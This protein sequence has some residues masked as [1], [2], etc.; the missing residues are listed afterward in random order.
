M[1]SSWWTSSWIST[2]NVSFSLILQD[3]AGCS[4]G[5]TAV[6]AGSSLRNYGAS[7]MRLHCP[8]CGDILTSST[9]GSLECARGQMGLAPELERRLRE[10]YVTEIRQPKDVTFTYNDRPHPIG[11]T[12]FCPGCGVQAQE[13]SPGDLRCPSCSR[14]LVEFIYSLVER[15]PHLHN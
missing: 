14:S 7:P 15:H 8:K 11:G 1:S 4:P 10:C 6:R 3:A 13:L 2:T 5:Y 9:D 12:W